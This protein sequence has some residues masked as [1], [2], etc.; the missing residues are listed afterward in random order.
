MASGTT[1][2]PVAVVIDATVVIALC[3]NEADKLANAEAKIKEYS[4]KGCTFYAPGVIIVEC[5]FVFCRKLSDGVLTPVEH[6]S[7]VLSLMRLMRQIHPPPTGDKSLIERAEEIRGAFGC[8][9]SAD[10]IYLAL[11]EEL[12]AAMSTELVTFDAGMLNQAARSS[13]RMPVVVRPTV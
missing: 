3:A 12:N 1:T 4:G 6:S 13:L 2:S 5:L 9:R 10:G 8:S 7:A 11:A